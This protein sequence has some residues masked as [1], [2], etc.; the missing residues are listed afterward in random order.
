MDNEQ[1]LMRK[2]LAEEKIRLEQ[3]EARKAQ[4]GGQEEGAHEQP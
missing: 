1:A 4:E 3:Q 2:F